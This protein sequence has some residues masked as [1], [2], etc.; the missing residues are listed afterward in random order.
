M[1]VI[2]LDYTVT[3]GGGVHFR[4]GAEDGEENCI[5]VTSICDNN[6]EGNETITVLLQSTDEY[7]A[8]T[9]GAQFSG[10]IN[11]IIVETTG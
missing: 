6:E 1:T 9:I 7:Q 3:S 5:S 4:S 11:I 2:D 10:F 8:Q